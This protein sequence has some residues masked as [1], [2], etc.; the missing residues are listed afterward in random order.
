MQ[1]QPDTLC[2]QVSVHCML[3]GRVFSMPSSFLIMVTLIGSVLSCTSHRDVR[4]Q[5]SSI[6]RY[7][8]LAQEK[9]GDGVEFVHNSTKTAVLCLKKSKPTLQVPQQQ[10]A[11]FVFDLASDTVIFEDSIPNGSVQWK[12]DFSIVV[13][14]TPG[15]E[16]G[17]DV[18]PPARHGYIFDIRIRKTRELNSTPVQ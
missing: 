2:A 7:Q 10:V 17:E 12:D 16:K 13:N 1:S 4:Q 8:S 14:I 9:Y 18:S 11:F 5:Q 6:A 3:R 15:I